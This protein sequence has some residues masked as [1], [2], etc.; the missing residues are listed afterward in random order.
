M[1]SSVNKQFAPMSIYFKLFEKLLNIH[2]I[3]FAK[4]RWPILFVSFKI[5]VKS[6]YAK[7]QLKSKILPLHF[8]ILT[9]LYIM[10][11]NSIQNQICTMLINAS[12]YIQL[13]E[14]DHDV[15]LKM[16]LQ[17]SFSLLCLLNFH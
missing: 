5:L 17:K 3:S 16:I 10:V 6:C 2:P 13:C 11:E 8:I 4:K 12:Q 15:M 9:D 14:N 7:K 1:C